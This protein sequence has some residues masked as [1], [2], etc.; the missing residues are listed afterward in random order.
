MRYP[1]PGRSVFAVVCGLLAGVAATSAVATELT[2]IHP[3]MNTRF[4]A[5]GGTY[6]ANSDPHFRLDDGND[7]GTEISGSDLGI[8]DDLVVPVGELRWRITDRWRLE[9][10]YFGLDE[11]GSQIFKRRVE[12]GDL[13]F[14]AGAK[15]K[16]KVKT[17][18]WRALLGYSF[19]KRDRWELGAGLGLHWLSF[20]AKLT[21]QASLN[22]SP[23]AEAS[24]KADVS[25]PVP[26]IGFY[27]DYAFNQRWLVSG[28]IDWFSANVDD[29][30][31]RLWRV[32]AAVV[33][34]PFKHVNFG[35]G[36]D[37]LD[38]DVDIDKD[39]WNGNIDSDYYGPSV[40]LGL[41]F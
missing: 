2:G 41:T 25:G 6:F 27:S 40:F 24:Q 36:Y 11:S 34:Q 21:G 5:S 4:Q 1:F 35:F 20:E 30:D 39:D 38:I 12:W 8:D 15:V 14:S 18:I 23:V 16:S 3:T 29:F 7:E 10:L 28:R 22:G 32:G 17:D 26:N 13:D 9:G 19:V 31:G 37:Y 33:Y